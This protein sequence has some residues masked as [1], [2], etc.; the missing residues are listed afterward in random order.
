MM[1]RSTARTGSAITSLSPSTTRQ[2]FARSASSIEPTISRAFATLCSRAGISS[3]ALVA[4]GWV[5]WGTE[6]GDCRE[7]S[8]MAPGIVATCSAS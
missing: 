4:L 5:N 6:K 7:I 2:V 8:A 3:A 1:D